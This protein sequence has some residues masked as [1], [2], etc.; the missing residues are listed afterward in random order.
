[1]ESKNFAINV[2]NGGMIK[3]AIHYSNSKTQSEFPFPMETIKFNEKEFLIFRNCNS[4]LI[5]SMHSSNSIGDHD[6]FYGNV[7]EIV[8]F[9]DAMPLLYFKSE[10]HTP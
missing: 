2:L 9:K 5:C 3:E 4:S 1:M 6:V 8:K 7:E 10:F